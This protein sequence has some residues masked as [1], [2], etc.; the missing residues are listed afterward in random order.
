MKKDFST[1]TLIVSVNVVG[2]FQM[3]FHISYS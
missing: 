3:L 1:C 2:E